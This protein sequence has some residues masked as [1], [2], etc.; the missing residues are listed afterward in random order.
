MR[1]Y[2]IAATSCDETFAWRCHRSVYRVSRRYDLQ[3]RHSR[4]TAADRQLEWEIES[5][6]ESERRIGQVCVHSFQFNAS[7]THKLAQTP[8]FLFLVQLPRAT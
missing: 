3:L 4:A 5:E 1:Y 6:S 7:H 8:L 2:S